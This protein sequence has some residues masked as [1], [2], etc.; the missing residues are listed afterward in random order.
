MGMSRVIYNDFTFPDRSNFRV[1]E[2]F[3]YDDAG[4]TVVATRFRLNVQTIICV[5]NVS[6]GAS[7]DSPD[8]DCGDA[9][10]LRDEPCAN[11]RLHEEP[12][13]ATEASCAVPV[14]T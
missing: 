14:P 10:H 9:S 11:A 8:Y 12:V 1:D 2:E 13:F 5:E 7:Y 4:I 3:I 6:P